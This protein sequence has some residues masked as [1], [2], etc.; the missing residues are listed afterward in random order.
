VTK[1]F[2]FLVPFIWCYIGFLYLYGHLFFFRLR[3]FSSTTFLKTFLGLLN[4]NL[5]CDVVTIRS[6]RSKHLI[7]LSQLLHCEDAPV[8]GMIDQH[9]HWA[10]QMCLGEQRESSL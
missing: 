10:R 4:W 8:E 3:E 7:L 2:C 1:G 6:L 9:A 5:T